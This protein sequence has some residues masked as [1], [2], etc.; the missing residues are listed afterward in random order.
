M[1]C[2][3]KSSRISVVSKQPILT[4][5]LFVLTPGQIWPE[6]ILMIG[7]SYTWPSEKILD[8]FAF[9]FRD[10]SGAKQ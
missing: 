4:K 5:D 9:P 6:V 3:V 2:Q 7:D 8:S 1:L 10:A